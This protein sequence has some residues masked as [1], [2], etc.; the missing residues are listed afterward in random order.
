MAATRRRRIARF[1]AKWRTEY[2]VATVVFYVVV[3]I[4]MTVWLFPDSNIWLALLIVLVSFIE[5]LKDL[6][7]QLKAEE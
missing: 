2:S 1:I 5:Q 3:I 4:P 6:A 7:D